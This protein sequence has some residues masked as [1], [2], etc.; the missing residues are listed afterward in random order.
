[1]IQETAGPDI[2]SGTVDIKYSYDNITW[3]QWNYNNSNI[4]VSPNQSVMFKGNNPTGMKKNRFQS[5]PSDA[6]FSL[7]GNIMSLLYNDEF[8][9]KTTVP[10]AAF[11]YLFTSSIGLRNAGDL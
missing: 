5:S 7:S 10:P 9:D 11:A 1:M 6:R 8:S 3:N 2:P 4:T